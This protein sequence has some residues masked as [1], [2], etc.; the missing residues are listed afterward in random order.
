MCAQK[1][2]QPH[3]HSETEPQTYLTGVSIGM[4]KLYKLE[5]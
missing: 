1:G 5:E 4:N 2:R 3:Y